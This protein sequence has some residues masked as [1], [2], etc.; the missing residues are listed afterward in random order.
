MAMGALLS[1]PL[2]SSDLPEEVPTLNTREAD[3]VKV[4]AGRKEG[5]EADFSERI[6]GFGVG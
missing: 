2:V 4:E 6:Q 3:L 1:A 5:A